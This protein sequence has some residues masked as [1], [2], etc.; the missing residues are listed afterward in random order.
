MAHPSDLAPVLVALKATAI[1]MG[2]DGRRE[3]PFEDFFLGPN[4]LIE[5][6][7]NPDEFISEIQIPL[8]V[9]KT[10]QVF[11]KNRIRNS[12]DFALASVAMVARMS[13]EICQEIRMV[14]GGVAPLPYVPSKAEG[15]VKGRNFDERIISEAAE[16][17]VEGAHAL[18]MNQYKVPLTRSLVRRALISIW[19]E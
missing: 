17:A 14:L 4:N 10:R 7:L 19:H 8:Q 2:S 6:V 5:T 1:T 16:V 12:A 15:M 3:V 13:G 9:G 11:L 18:P